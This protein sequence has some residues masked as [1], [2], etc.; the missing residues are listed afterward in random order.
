MSNETKERFPLRMK[1]ETSRRLEQWYAADNCR[2]KNEFVEKAI[3]FYVDYLETQDNQSLLPTALQAALD[4]RLGRLEDRIAR[5]EFTREVELDLLI[6]I[7]ADA[8]EVDRDEL[9]R[10]RAQSVRNVRA[11]N[12]L[13]SLEKRAR[14]V[15]E[16]DWDDDEW[17]N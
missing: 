6:G 2:S 13:I 16:P 1:P 10:R 17:Q 4:G 7:I 14:S 9:K 15:G 3:N 5:R 11:T 12:G 8:V